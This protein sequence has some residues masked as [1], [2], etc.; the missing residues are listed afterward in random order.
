MRRIVYLDNAATTKLSKH[1]KNAMLPYLEDSYGNPSSVYSFAGDAKNA[2][3]DSRKKIA[4]AVGARPEEIFFTSGGTESD[5]W[6]IVSAAEL[7][8]EKGKHIITSA[9]EHPAVMSTLE[10][11]EKKGYEVT[12]LNVDGYGRI[13]LDGLRKAIRDDTILITIMTANNE[14]GTIMPVPEI[15]TVAKENNILFH[16]DAVQAVGHV[17]VDVNEMNADMVSFSGH[18]F[19]AA[20]GVGA[21][22]VKRGL[23]LPPL[24][25]GGGQERGRRS[26]TENVAGIVSMGAALEDITARL[27]LTNVMRLR[28][29]LIDGVLKNIPRTRLTGDPVNRLPGIAS[30]VFEAVEGESM[31]LM[32]DQYGICASSGSACSSGSLDP[33]HVLLAIGLAHEEAHGSLR[34]SLS[35]DNTDGDIDLVIEKLP[36]IIEKLRRMSPLWNE[37]K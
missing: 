33:S 4:N 26:G 8:K 28:D 11:L 22:Y 36:G 3:E 10:H 18:K 30:F 21:L 19:G 23:R 25:Y 32:L 13:S 29:R 16:T 1:A 12:Y 34:F 20:K 7:K 5:N 17:R 9:I 2:V 35:E 14:I 6:A 37:G 27:P 24:I 15:G 31:L